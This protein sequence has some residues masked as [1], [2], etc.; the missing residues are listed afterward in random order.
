MNKQKYYKVG[1]IPQNWKQLM[2]MGDN[3]FASNDRL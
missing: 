3:H 2:R 1:E